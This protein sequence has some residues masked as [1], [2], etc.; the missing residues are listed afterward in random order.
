MCELSDEMQNEIGVFYSSYLQI[1]ESPNSTLQQKW[2]IVQVLLQ[3][4]K[5]P[6]ALVD[7]FVNYDCDLDAK[8]I[9]E[10]C[11]DQLSHLIP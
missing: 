9:Y 1:L 10:R 6:Q 2:M 5:N 8:D 7:I 3:I 11:L 4:C